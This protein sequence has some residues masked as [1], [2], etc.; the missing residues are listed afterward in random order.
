MP[1]ILITGRNSTIAQEYQRWS[2][3]YFNKMPKSFAETFHFHRFDVSKPAL[4]GFNPH[5]DRYLFC[6]GLLIPKKEDELTEQE[7]HEMQ[8]ANYTS[9]VKAI[10]EILQCNDNARICVI[11]SESGYRGS[12]NGLYAKMKGYLSD[13]ISRKQLRTANQ[14]LVGISPGI[15]ADAGMTTRRKDQHNVEA[16][17]QAHRMGYHI[18]SAE[19]AAMAFALLHQFRYVSG[20]IIRMHGETDT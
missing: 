17:A 19:V 16:R 3:A 7:S 8:F 10:S 2:T 20:T 14:Q 15:I 9:T 5:H 1:T 18:S 11:T 13:Y 6:H 12:Y 4:E